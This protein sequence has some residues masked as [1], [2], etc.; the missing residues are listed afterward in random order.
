MHLVRV[1]KERDAIFPAQSRE[2][3]FD[4]RQRPDE[5]V[6]PRLAQIL[7]RSAISRF[8]AE[9]IVELLDAAEGL[10]DEDFEAEEE[11]EE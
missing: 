9:E 8:V 3:I 2:E 5:E 11:A 6:R 1:R 10:E 4:S 7:E